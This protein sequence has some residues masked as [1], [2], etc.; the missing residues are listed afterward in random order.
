MESKIISHLKFLLK[1]T[2]AHGV[3]SPFVFQ[4]VTQCLY[5]GKKM[6]RDKSINVLLKSNA[7]FK[8]NSIHMDPNPSLE[9]TVKEMFPNVHFDTKPADVIYT[10]RLDNTRFEKLL[11]K[12]TMHNDSMILV[13]GIHQN[14]K[15]MEDWKT[16]IASPKITVS[17]DMF[18]CGAVFIRKE[19]VKEHFTI[20][21]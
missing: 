10:D 20:R 21:I 4:Y 6:H 16:L 1:S 13:E 18:H 3:H 11:S 14:E 17:I 19:Q 7:H 8:A 9:K 5:A 12:G 2:N 15:K